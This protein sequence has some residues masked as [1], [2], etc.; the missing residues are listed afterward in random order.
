MS[1]P[2]FAAWMT[3][4]GRGRGRISD[5]QAAEM[6]GVGRNSIGQFRRGERPVPVAVALACAA[7]A[8]GLPP[9]RRAA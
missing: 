6:L 3:H 7:L 1:G 5:G 2:D 8:Y 9:W 4:I